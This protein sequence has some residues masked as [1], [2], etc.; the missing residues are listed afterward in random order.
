MSENQPDNRHSRI[1]QQQCYK[2]LPGSYGNG[3]LDGPID[4]ATSKGK[5]NSGLKRNTAAAKREQR[6][7]KNV[8]LL[9]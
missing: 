2:F 4:H 9:D 7:L 5:E 1:S 6:L 8:G 3:H